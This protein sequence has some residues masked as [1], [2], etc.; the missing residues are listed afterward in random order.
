MNIAFKNLFGK[1]N[2]GPHTPK[3]L[4]PPEPLVPLVS[5]EEPIMSTAHRLLSTVFCRSPRPLPLRPHLA[6]PSVTSSRVSGQGT[7]SSAPW[8]GLYFEE[9]PTA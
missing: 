4:K 8:V 1:A 5:F 2:G 9:T 6:S 7:W 3:N